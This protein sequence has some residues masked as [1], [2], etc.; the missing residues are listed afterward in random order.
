MTD[1]INTWPE[2]R[3]LVTGGAGFIGSNLAESIRRSDRPVRVADSFITGRRENLTDIDGIELYE[4]DLRD[5]EFCRKCMVDVDWVLHQA[6]LGSVPRSVEDPVTTNAH[7]VT[8]TLNVLTAAKEAKVGRVVMASSSSAY[9][10]TPQLP[11]VE[12]MPPMPL[13]PYAVSKLVGEFYAGVFWRTY[14][15]PTVCLRYFNVF[16]RRQDPNSAYAA[17]LPLFIRHLLAGNAPEIHGDGEQTRDFTYIDNVIEANRLAV[18]AGENAFGQT[19]N[20]AYGQRIS[21][22]ELYRKVAELLGSD[23]EPSYTDSRAGDVKHS[24]ASVDKATE[25]LGYHPAI[26]IFE[27]LELTI[28]WYRQALAPR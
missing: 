1:H 11:K 28:D 10:N 24:L 14:G 21:L 26:D 17:V 18:M 19:V 13:S 20:I 27:G 12:S 3:Y 5:L 8:A 15:L 25:L 4:G 23:I 16:G 7:N 6:A 22:N 2:G 9:G